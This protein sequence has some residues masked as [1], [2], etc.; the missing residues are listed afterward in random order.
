MNKSLKLLTAKDF[1]LSRPLLFQQTVAQFR[2]QQLHL[3]ALRI[4]HPEVLQTFD[5]VIGNLINP[6]LDLDA[7]VRTSKT[8]FTTTFHKIAADGSNWNGLGVGQKQ[9]IQPLNDICQHSL[10]AMMCL[11]L[12]SED[13]TEKGLVI[14]NVEVRFFMERIVEDVSRFAKEKFG[15]CPEIQVRGD[16]RISMI[17]PFIEFVT[18]ELLKNAIKA[19]IDR[20]GALD[21][22]DAPPIVILLNPQGGKGGLLAFQ[23]HG[24][25]MREEVADRYV[26]PAMPKLFNLGQV[27]S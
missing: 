9:L 24:I 17:P 4:R 23:D 16:M 3:N 6:K 8:L 15:V 22:D 25:G 21:I 13:A 1:V 27:G 5:K 12:L 26:M 11:D 14:S 20:Y 19:V 18:V 7:R 2:R 10:H